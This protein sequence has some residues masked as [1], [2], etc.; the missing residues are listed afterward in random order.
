MAED[1]SYRPTWREWWRL[2]MDSTMNVRGL[3][4]WGACL[5][6]FR[7]STPATK[8]A[9]VAAVA[10]VATMAVFWA[11]RGREATASGWGNEASIGT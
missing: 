9:I 10:I 11:T 3:E 7:S 5:K 8:R 1:A 4:G 6:E 2:E